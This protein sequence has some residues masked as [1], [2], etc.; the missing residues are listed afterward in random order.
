MPLPALVSFGGG[1][2]RRR[3]LFLPTRRGLGPWTFGATVSLLLAIG[4]ALGFLAF[5]GPVALLSTVVAGS[6]LLRT[7]LV[8]R[9]GACILLYESIGLG[10]SDGLRAAGKVAKGGRQG[11]GISCM[12]GWG[13]LLVVILIA[14][15]INNLAADV[16]VS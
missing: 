8:L 7:V 12:P 3:G 9:T 1:F 14:V 5:P 15:H 6:R 2:T 11:F 13:P 10:S 16:T 4:V